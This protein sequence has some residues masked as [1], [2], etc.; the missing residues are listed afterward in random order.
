MSTDAA[1]QDPEAITRLEEGVKRVRS[2]I[3]KVIIGQDQVVNE[4]MIAILTRSHALLVGVPGLAKTLLVSSLAEALHLS[5]KRIQFTPDLMPSDITGTEVIYSDPATNEREFKFLR[6]PIFANI[7]LAD[8]INRTPPK[9]QAAML[10]SMQE[11][12]VTVGGEDHLLPEPFFVLATQNPIE[13]EGTYPLPEAQLDRFMFMIK[14]DYPSE[15]EEFQ[16]MKTYTGNE[17]GK[18][19]PVLTAEEILEMQRAVRNMPVADHIIRYAEKLVRVTRPNSEEALEF[20]TKWLTWGAGPR[21]GLNLV[22]AAK[23]HA[24]LKGESHVSCDDIAAVAPPI[25]R[26]RIIPNFSAQSEGLTPDDITAKILE[27]VPKDKKLD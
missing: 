10:E 19:D 5:F 3:S 14:V 25:F 27:S 23:A 16:I 26:H 17:A 18:P 24:L 13:Q 1:T 15:E 9:T 20:C 21:A 6:G 7:I 12:K 8:E 2:E 4:V 11:R 22:L